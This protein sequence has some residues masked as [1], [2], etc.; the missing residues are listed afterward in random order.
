MQIYCLV[1][2]YYAQLVEHSSKPHFYFMFYQ[3]P[4]FIKNIAKLDLL[5]SRKPSEQLVALQAEFDVAECNLLVWQQHM[6]EHGLDISKMRQKRAAEFVAGR[7]LAWLAL[8]QLTGQNQA[9]LPI[10]E[11]R[12]PIWPK[13]VVGSISHSNGH[14]VVVVKPAA[15]QSSLGIDIEQILSNDKAQTLYKE[16]INPD[17]LT[18]LNSSGDFSAHDFA[19][20]VSLVFS[21]KEAIYKA[22]YPLV[23]T[24]FS[25]DAVELT[26]IDKGQL[27]FKLT[28]MFPLAGRKILADQPI[29]VSWIQQQDMVF[30]WV[31]EG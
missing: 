7:Y 4:N 8:Q 19:L 16:F 15:E 22:Y 17:E 30:S 31:M 18:V 20:L 6:A 28:E 5:C 13:G 24:F 14:V 21:A 27:V 25:F 9:V 1:Q 2:C 29:I 23:Q 3:Q 11:D 26:S 12:A 10:G